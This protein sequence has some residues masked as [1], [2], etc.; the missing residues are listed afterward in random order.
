MQ[1]LD[2]LH[3]DVKQVA[4]LAVRVGCVADAVELQVDIAQTGFSSR[5]G[6]ILGLGELDAVGRGL[7]QL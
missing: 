7:D 5:R 3:L 6:K 2:G 4:D 1:V